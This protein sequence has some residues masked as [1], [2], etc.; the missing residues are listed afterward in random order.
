[1]GIWRRVLG[2]SA[3]GAMGVLGPGSLLLSWR[4][5]GPAEPRIK[6]LAAFGGPA[7]WIM[8]MLGF[9]HVI[10]P[11]CELEIASL[12]VALLWA[13]APGAV[14]V[15]TSLGLAEGQPKKPAAN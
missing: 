6:S 10:L 2:F 4:F 14:L 15:G 11:H 9:F 1:M 5:L 7:L 12:I 3:L 8:W 13:L